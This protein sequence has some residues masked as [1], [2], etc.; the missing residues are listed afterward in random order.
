M[1]FRIAIAAWCAAM[2]MLTAGNAIA[3]PAASEPDAS[4]T[5]S[6]S[7]G[8][9]ST[10]PEEPVEAS[11]SGDGMSASETSNINSEL[12]VA[13]E[14]EPPALKSGVER[15]VAGLYAASPAASASGAGHKMNPCGD[16]FYSM[17]SGAGEI[18]LIK[19]SGGYEHIGRVQWLNDKNGGPLPGE[20]KFGYDA[21]AIAADGSMWHIE[22]DG[23]TTPGANPPTVI[24]HGMLSDSTKDGYQTIKQYRLT[25]PSMPIKGGTMTPDGKYIM[26][27]D[28][29]TAANAFSGTGSLLR[30]FLFD[31]ATENLSMLGDIADKNLSTSK[32]SDLA[33]DKQGNLYLL[34]AAAEGRK[35]SDGVNLPPK[36]TLV[37]IFRINAQDFQSA[38]KKA[39]VKKLVEGKK[40][41]N[42]LKAQDL[43]LQEL[44]STQ[45]RDIVLNTP[46][47][48][49]GGLAF[50]G[51]GEFYLGGLYSGQNVAA[52]RPISSVYQVNIS[53]GE[54]MNGG[55]PIFQ[56]PRAA[57]K[58]D[59]RPDYNGKWADQQIV[60]LEGCPANIP[61]ITV[62][63]NIVERVHSSDQFEVTVREIIP[64]QSIL[65]GTGQSTV[66]TTGSGTGPQPNSLALLRQTGSPYILEERM[67]DG[68]KSKLDDY[69]SNWSCV[70]EDGVSIPV[71]ASSLNSGVLQTE[72]T[73]AVGGMVTCT[74][75][76][77][78][79]T[80]SVSV[81]K[82]DGYW[83]ED[84]KYKEEIVPGAKFNICQDQ[85][86]NGKCDSTEPLL[87]EKVSTNEA[88]TW[89]NLFVGKKYVLYEVEAPQGY[90]RAANLAFDATSGELI[91]IVP[92][93]R[94]TG[95][96]TWQKKAAGSE[97]LLK[98]SVWT[99]SSG[100]QK[101]ADI[102]DCVEKDAA[103]CGSG[104]WA[105]KDPEAGKFKIEGLQWADYKLSEKSAPL[106]Y[107]IT[108]K[109]YEFG[110]NKDNV[111]VPM[112]LG[113]I[114]NE[115]REGPI[116]PMAGGWAEQ[117]FRIAGITVLAGAAAACCVLA[118]RRRKSG[119]KAG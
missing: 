43:K 96:V 116:M 59:G 15:S 1:K 35:H 14:T 4:S 109:I 50:G 90:I 85:N 110:F 11:E 2:M 93:K 107:V 37:H 100:D 102:S 34:S 108:D 38:Q 106:G 66:V 48:E 117:F 12:Q 44:K 98:G 13:E 54:F 16:G 69:K 32:F 64:T 6:P 82:Y 61:T 74:V 65:G 56:A 39:V 30:L 86:A 71:K 118:V 81:L 94:M 68:S 51:N 84:D 28:A 47:F 111:S 52:E 62:N 27:G 26:V 72:V 17:S 78:P 25:N 45:L 18:N 77:S 63:K 97:K 101:V 67:A 20:K 75:T 21:L 87:G 8:P 99:L 22:I 49:I 105:D 76:N 80:T 5:S 10:D 114:E 7:T 9:I 19:A 95:T 89:N 33:F 3:S 41:T 70:S 40:A 88:I 55:K 57:N 104:R 46:S 92:N 112:D 79:K 24:R 53:S 31:P 60:D 103:K 42:D 36:K 73:P 83:F 91:K 115:M 58:P 29:G 113:A 119:V 23:L